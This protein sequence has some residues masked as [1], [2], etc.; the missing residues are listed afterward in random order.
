MKTISFED[1]M[2]LIIAEFY[3]YSFA[4]I[5]KNYQRCKS[6]DKTIESLKLEQA[7]GVAPID[8]IQL[9]EL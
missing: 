2:L 9:N 3:P 6:C 4:E 7:F 5:K 8:I 1:K